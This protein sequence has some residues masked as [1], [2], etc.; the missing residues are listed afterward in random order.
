MSESV[1]ILIG[2]GGHAES[3]IDVIEQE[4]RYQVG[5][6]LGK[7]DEIGRNI[8]GYKVLGVDEDLAQLVTRFGFA[9]IA[10]G[11]TKSPD[12]RMRL[13]K[14]VVALGYKLPTIVAPSAYVSRNAKLGSG[15]IVMHGAII[16][17]GADVGCNCIINSRALVEHGAFVG[18][19]CHISTGAILNG[20]TK[21]GSGSFIGSSSSIKEGI[22]LGLRCLVGMGIFVRHH[23]ADNA[24]VVANCEHE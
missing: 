7:S 15:T 18:D 1:V 13:Y 19:H 24:R 20:Q 22:S 12:I 2:A 4:G 14:S 23:Q 10:V 9:L 16:N 5:G 6:L 17:T 21:V 3:C 11:Q 8:N